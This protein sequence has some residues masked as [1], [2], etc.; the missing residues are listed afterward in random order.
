MS[1]ARSSKASTRVELFGGPVARIRGEEVTFSPHQMPLVALIFGHRE[2]RISRAE[3]IWLIWEEDDGPGPRHKL[4]QLLRDVQ[5]RMEV[6]IVESNSD[7]LQADTSVTSNDLDDFFQ[8]LD[9]GQ[10][11][12]A[13]KI[14]RLGFAANLTATSAPLADWLEG[15]RAT[16]ANKLRRAAAGTWDDCVTLDDWGSAR[17]AAEALYLIAPD[18]EASVAKVIEARAR[19]GR[20]ASA[21]AA[22]ASHVQSLAPDAR[23]SDRLDDLMVRVRALPDTPTSVGAGRPGVPLFG[24][25]AQLAEASTIFE[26][27]QSGNLD[28]LLVSGEAGIGKTRLMEELRTKAVLE[29]FTCLLARPVELEQKIALNPI[30]DALESVDL[31][32]HLLALGDPWRAVISSF[33]PASR[34]DGPPG[35]IPYVQDSSLSR[36]LLDAF[37]M[38]FDRLAQVGPTLLFLD[39][40]HWAD[41][42]TIVLLQFMQ[43]RWESG[44]LGVVAAARP[45]LVRK[46]DPLSVLIQGSDGSSVRTVHLG[47]L[48]DSDARRLVDHVADRALD[49]TTGAHLCDLAANHPF[50]LTEVTKDFV[51]GRLSLP[52]RT[53]ETIPIPIS[54][55]QIFDVRIG[56]LSE[57]ATR[58][59]EVLAVRARSMRLVDVGRLTDLE[60]DD[61]V[62]RIE[63]LQ[64][65]HFVDVDHGNVSISHEL[66]RSALYKHIGDARRPL[67]HGRVGTH[68]SLSTPRSC[69]A[70]WRS[71]SRKPGSPS[72]QSTMLRSPRQK[73]V[74]AARPRQRPTSSRSWCRTRPTRSGA[75]PRPRSWPRLCTW[76][77]RW[78]ARIPCS[79]SRRHVSGSRAT[80]QPLGAW[81][82]DGLKGWPR[83]ARCLSQI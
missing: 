72:E 49:N 82:F 46:G 17:D 40:I 83:A 78:R 7:P 67:L 14:L 64:R 57:G 11:L 34:I 58:V 54:L 63:E 23:A 2:G 3:A 45:E 32:P 43:R 8:S 59:A 39:D 71:T 70:N 79:S 76:I 1:R 62:D 27:V 6:R 51:A 29:G 55:R 16:F 47:E 80:T 5:E 24:R 69:R 66:F 68:W 19:V 65:S 28:L 75:R 37:W 42:T 31:R 61:C 77:G 74:R 22:Y 36:R 56:N 50:Y 9:D 44:P 35:E 10:L 18:D 4:R 48:D 60:V 41:P 21:E 53:L 81:R 12:N 73:L 26:S 25:S 38:L 52:E 15:R 33:L 13:A 20:I 30:I